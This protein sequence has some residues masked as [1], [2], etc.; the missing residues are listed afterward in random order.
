MMSGGVN[1]SYIPPKQVNEKLNKVGSFFAVWI[2]ENS[3]MLVIKLPK[4][5]NSA[6]KSK[7]QHYVEEQARVKRISLSLNLYLLGV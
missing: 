3:I 6:Q 2:P 4:W 7:W 1:C 5:I